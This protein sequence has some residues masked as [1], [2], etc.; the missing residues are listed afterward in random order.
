MGHINYTAIMA[1]EEEGAGVAPIKASLL[2]YQALSFL[3]FL[4]LSL[5]TV[6]TR[7][8]V[9]VKVLCPPKKNLVGGG[10]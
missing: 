1:I 3:L 9:K 2:P 10:C 6:R 4:A 5:F 7:T 8:V